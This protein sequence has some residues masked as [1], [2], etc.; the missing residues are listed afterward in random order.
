MKYTVTT[1]DKI[2]KI[3]HEA[4]YVI[5][6]ERVKFPKWILY[7]RRKKVL[8]LNKFLCALEGRINTLTDILPQLNVDPESLPQESRKV[9]ENL[10]K[11][12][13]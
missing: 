9:L 1:L 13:S 2:E 10:L 12:Q 5:R 4:G 8:V 7:S 3:M 11:P 6:Y